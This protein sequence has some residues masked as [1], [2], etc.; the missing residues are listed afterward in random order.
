MNT[1]NKQNNR[2]VVKK[3]SEPDRTIFKNDNIECRTFCS[4]ENINNH[5]VLMKFPFAAK[6]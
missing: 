4:V 5:K 6:K 1:N 3:S 2:E